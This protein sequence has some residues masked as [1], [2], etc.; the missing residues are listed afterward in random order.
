MSGVQDP[1]FLAS[2]KGDLVVRMIGY[3]Q[4]SAARHQRVQCPFVSS[5][6]EEV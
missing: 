2:K 4:A 6:V 1:A 3:T 5:E